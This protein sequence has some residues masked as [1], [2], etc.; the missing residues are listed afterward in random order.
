[1]SGLEKNAL[2]LTRHFKIQVIIR[3]FLGTQPGYVPAGLPLEGITQESIK[4]SLT[5]GAVVAW[6]ACAMVKT[7]H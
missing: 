5:R 1:M 2:L 4:R 7:R 3:G 6:R